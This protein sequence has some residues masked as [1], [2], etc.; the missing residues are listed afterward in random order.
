MSLVDQRRVG[1]CAALPGVQI[2]QERPGHRSRRAIGRRV[3]R[4]AAE[5]G[6][7]GAQACGGATDIGSEGG[8]RIVD[9][10]RRERARAEV[11]VGVG[12]DED[13]ARILAYVRAGLTQNMQMNR[14]K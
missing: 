4:A 12:V 1:D 10:E 7:Q 6:G 2:A 8:R 13:L 3:G 14:T 5:R 11:G 9:H